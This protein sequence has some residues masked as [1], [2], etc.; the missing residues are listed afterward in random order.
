M[1][2][3]STPIFIQGNSHPAEE[4]RLM[5]AGMLGAA[6]GSFAGGVASSDPAHGVARGADLA[7]T[8]N[9]TPNMTVN[10]A[11]GGCFIRGTQSANQGAY[12]L[13]N[14]ASLSVAISAADATNS[15]RDLIVA[16]VRDA[17][18]SGASSDAR[19]VVVTGTPAASPVDPTV[20]ANSLVLARVA[21]AAG[22]TSI[23]TANITDLRTMAN[24][25]NACPAFGSTTQRDQFIPVP[26]AGQNVQI[27][28]GTT[29]RFMSYDGTAWRD[30]PS[31]SRIHGVHLGHTLQQVINNVTPTVSGLNYEF[32]DS[33]NYHSTVTNNS[34]ITIP[35]GLAG[36][37]AVNGYIRYDSSSVTSPILGIYVNGSAVTRM[38]GQTGPFAAIAISATL[39]LAAGDYIELFTYHSTGAARL[40]DTVPTPN[41][42]DP[43]APQL[44]AYMIGGPRV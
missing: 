38:I 31:I 42:I 32:Y 29:N 11:A 18:Y 12:H 26:Y 21:V 14:D 44:S 1:P 33:D 5:L 4:T 16:Q 3:R 37:Y 23:V 27:V 24:I 7:V 36:M 34:R 10:V 25:L 30:L 43:I 2:V 39:P 40:L 13:W 28:T 20:P 17:N 19:I 6:T 22:A 15:R 9:G 41:N 35:A 8:Q